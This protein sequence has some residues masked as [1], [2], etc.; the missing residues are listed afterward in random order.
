[1]RKDS[2]E[3]ARLLNLSDSVFAVAMTFLAFTIALPRP[4]EHASL[5]DQLIALLPQLFALGF[6]YFVVARVWLVH[7]RIFRHMASSHAML[8][9]LEFVLLFWV[10]ILP[11]SADLLGTW[12]LQFLT[13]IIYA[14]NAAAIGITQLVT[15]RHA[16]HHRLPDSESGDLRILLFQIELL[17]AVFVASMPISWFNPRIAVLSWLSLLPL[18]FLLPRAIPQK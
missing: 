2:I 14:T 11:F 6:S 3:I 17:P 13:V 4:A 12:P 9:V 16:M 18:Q 10:V 7:H 5:P 1:M 8:A 15:T